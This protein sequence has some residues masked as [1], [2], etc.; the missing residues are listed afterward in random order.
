MIDKFKDKFVDEALDNVHDLEEALLL[1][2][3][4]RTNRE[5]IERIFRAMHSLKGGGAMFG[6]NDLSDFTHHLE[7]VF[8]LVRNGK[9]DVSDNIITITLSAID[10]IKYLLDV[11]DLNSNEDRK[12]QN[13]LIESVQNIISGD[14]KSKVIS[15]Q[16]SLSAPTKIIDE[17]KS[18][19]IS[20]EPDSDILKNGTNPFFLLDDLHAMGNAVSIPFFKTLPN[21]SELNPTNHYSSWQVILNTKSSVNEVKDVFIFVEDECKIEI[22][23]ISNDDVLK[24]NQLL[25]LVDNAI[26]DNSPLS[27]DAIISILGEELQH[28][29]ESEEENESGSERKRVAIKEHKISSI[30][31]ASNKI[32][33]LVNLV[34]ELVTIQAQLNLYAEKSGESSIVTLAESIQKLSKQL[35][36]NAFE[37]SLIPLQTEIMRFQRL[38]R[39][40]SKDL[41]KEID[42]VVE[43]ADIELDKN[44]IEHLTDPLLH[45]IRNSIDHG[46]E[47]PEER[48]RQGKPPKGTIFFKAFY[49]GANVIIRVI[50]DGKGI[51]PEFIRRKAIDKGIID[52]NAELTKKEIF[53]LLFV[54]GF[55][56]RE[57]VSDLSGRGVGMDVVKRKIGEIRGEVVV[58]SEIHMGTTTTLELP[59]TLSI[60]DGLLMKVNDNSYV[61]PIA[62]IEKIFEVSQGKFNDILSNIITIDNKQYNY[63]DLR[64]IFGEAKNNDGNDQLILVKFEDKTVGL[65][66]DQVVGEYQTVVKPLGRYLKSHETISGASIL[67]DGS[68]AFVIDTNR[69]IHYQTYR[70]KTIIA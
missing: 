15:Q 65:I 22:S 37:I 61:I 63:I 24:N 14:K 8:D 45:I 43:G 38:V 17:S 39:D 20:F 1:L 58:D 66:V 25:E 46:I 16:E 52:K 70:K 5:I 68:V 10:H 33:E 69:L 59:L 21:F 28:N 36:D 56:T 50:D 47:M 7:T 53:D 29:L 34:S 64:D 62:S 9:L 67:G 60:I 11:G 19:L 12:K 48:I 54:S 31:V 44:I 32:D 13:I 35:R 6:F 23:E 51:D 40:V 2:E 4:N 55:S 49:S 3:V 57:V 18:F 41:N 27:L 30:R 42:F 26:N